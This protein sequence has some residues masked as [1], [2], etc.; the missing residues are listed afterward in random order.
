M[1]KKVW[2]STNCINELMHVKSSFRFRRRS[3]ISSHEWQ[4]E[5]K[6]SGMSQRQNVSLNTVSFCT[7]YRTHAQQGKPIFVLK[8]FYISISFTSLI[9]LHILKRSF[10]YS[11]NK[12][13]HHNTDNIS[14]DMH[15]GTRHV[16]LAKHGLWLPDDCFMWTE[17]CWSSFYNSV[18][19][20]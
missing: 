13:R 18:L 3:V 16:I 9:F 19:I 2:Q 20:I 17:T 4:T 11:L 1:K 14:N 10:Y 8:I 15:I 7:V 12:T 5:Q 6:F